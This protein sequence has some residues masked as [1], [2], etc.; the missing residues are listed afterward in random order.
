MGK[1]ELIEPPLQ[2]KGSILLREAEHEVLSKPLSKEEQKGFQKRKT[3]LPN[4]MPFIKVVDQN[5]QNVRD[6]QDCNPEHMA[7]NIGLKWTF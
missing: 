6:F 5:N 4:P 7:L 3:P 2:D 1:G